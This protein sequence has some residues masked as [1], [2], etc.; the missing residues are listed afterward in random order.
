[1]RDL[2]KE[3]R[4]GLVI[5]AGFVI[6]IFGMKFLKGLDL[7][8][9]G[10][11][12]YVV[13]DSVNGLN[14]GSP[15]VF[16][17]FKVGSVRKLSLHPSKKGKILVTCLLTEDLILAN[18]TK[19]QIFSLDILGAKG[20]NLLEGS[21][22]TMLMVNDTLSQSYEPSLKDQFDT[23]IGPLKAKL[24]TVIQRVDTFLLFTNQFL[25]PN[26]SKGLPQ[27]IQDFTV[28]MGNLKGISSNLNNEFAKGGAL[29]NSFKNLDTITS[30]LNS[31]SSSLGRIIVNLDTTTSQLRR[32]DLEATILQLKTVLSSASLILDSINQGKGSVGM[33]LKDESLYYNF[34]AS[35]EN[36]DRLLIDIR[37]NPKR[38]INISAFD[39]GKSVYLSPKGDGKNPDEMA[40]F[41][42]LLN[43]SNTPLDLK[44]HEIAG[45]IVEEVLWDKQYAY[46]L[47]KS[48]SFVDIKIL[49]ESVKPEFPNAEIIAIKDGNRIKLSKAMKKAVN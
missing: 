15:V 37:Q 27:G 17:G 23:E 5:V 38:Y 44:S 8:H 33:M 3:V 45:N 1:M 40:E 28:A 26:N 32:A 7:F 14:Q 48:K 2:S 6:L 39:F 13:Y 20:I 16:R 4:I 42:I 41:S 35:S 24:E 12:Y 47:G 11:N 31:R 36:L 25:N 19:A 21:S 9:K 29:S 49:Y 18:D 10:S 22:P 46:L 34:L 30:T 43:E